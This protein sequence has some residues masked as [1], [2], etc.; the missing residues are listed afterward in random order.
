MIAERVA[1]TRIQKII[2]ERMLSSKRSKPCFYIELKADV[3]ELLELRPKLRK[4]LGVK[5]TTN[6]FYVYALAEAAEKYPLVLGTIC[7]DKIKIADEINVGFAV[8]APHGL[9]VPVVKE[10]NKK[11]LAEIAKIESTLTALARDNQLTLDQLEGETIALSNLGA[12]GI[13]S[14]IGIVPPQA[15]VIVAVGNAVPTLTVREGK[16]VE[17]RMVSLTVACDRRVVSEIYA[18]QFLNYIK[19]QLENPLP[20]TGSVH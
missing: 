11:T 6:S 2:G 1:L 10:V 16:M 13:D 8:N 18:A 20:L 9:V 14:F 5:I 17:R 15:S 12:Y 19:E 4:T 7:D 3:T